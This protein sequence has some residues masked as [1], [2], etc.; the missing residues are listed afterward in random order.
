M[1]ANKLS[2]V[3]HCFIGWICKE[4]RNCHLFMYSRKRSPRNCVIKLRD[5]RIFKAL[6][7]IENSFKSIDF[8]LA[9][10]AL[11]SPPIYSCAGWVNFY[12]SGSYKIIT[13]VFTVVIITNS[14]ETTP[15]N[16]FR[17][18][19]ILRITNIKN[20]LLFLARKLYHIEKTLK[21]NVIIT[22]EV[23]WA[24]QHSLPIPVILYGSVESSK[25]SLSEKN[26]K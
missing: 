24:L 17:Y 1:L 21:R 2:N 20:V 7:W 14:E 15:C 9:K 3:L 26:P 6:L 23:K 5:N 8:D 12:W 11:A 10:H 18:S 16:S 19:Y 13:Y 22:G 25:V 4:P